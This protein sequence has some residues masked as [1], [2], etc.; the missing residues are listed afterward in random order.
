MYI[1]KM[2]IQEFIGEILYT[3]GFKPRWSTGIH[4]GYTAGFGK[5]DDNGYW[6]YPTHKAVRDNKEI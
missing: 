1:D 5:L 6:Q 4:G 2:A 3:L